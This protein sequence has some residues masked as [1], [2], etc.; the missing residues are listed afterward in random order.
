[1]AIAGYDTFTN[2]SA[3]IS[4][5][6]ARAIGKRRRGGEGHIYRDEIVRGGREEE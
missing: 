5:G 3:K 4:K 2:E 6:A 1:M